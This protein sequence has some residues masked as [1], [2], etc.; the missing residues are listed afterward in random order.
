[1][2]ASAA[3]AFQAAMGVAGDAQSSIIAPIHLLKAILDASENNLQANASYAVR[4]ASSIDFPLG[5]AAEDSAAVN[6]FAPFLQSGSVV[7]FAGS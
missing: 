5:A 2:S 4:M 7:G 6:S 1:M 3:E